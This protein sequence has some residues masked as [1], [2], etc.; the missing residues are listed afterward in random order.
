MLVGNTSNIASHM[1]RVQHQA[2]CS[3]SVGFIRNNPDTFVSQAT[4]ARFGLI[5]DREFPVVN[6]DDFR[7]GGARRKAFENA[8]IEGWSSRGTIYIDMGSRRDEIQALF[9]EHTAK[10][11]TVVNLPASKK[12][13]YRVPHTSWK[14]FDERLGRSAKMVLSTQRRD[15]EL[16]TDPRHQTPEIEAFMA[17]AQ[18]TAD[19]MFEVNVAI[20]Q[21]LDN[22]LKT[23]NLFQSMIVSPQGEHIS[24]SYTIN[25][26][27]E[28]V[29]PNAK[30]DGP[31]GQ[32]VGLDPHVDPTL[33]TL[34]PG[35]MQRGLFMVRCSSK[36]PDETFLYPIAPARGQI[37]VQGGLLIHFMT[38]E[39]IRANIHGVYR[40]NPDRRESIAM[41]VLPG[42]EYNIFDAA[43]SKY[44]PNIYGEDV[45][46]PGRHFGSFNLLNKPFH[47]LRIPDGYLNALGP[48]FQ[49]GTIVSFFFSQA[50]K[51]S[52][53]V[54]A[55][56]GRG[57]VAYRG[58]HDLSGAPREYGEIIYPAL[59]R[60]TLEAVYRYFLKSY[61]NL[62][63]TKHSRQELQKRDS[64]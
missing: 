56:Q 24:E 61:V 20:A 8:L 50:S 41:Q 9:D 45:R 7:A 18:K 37:A 5:R 14:G 40:D 32:V 49:P 22:V 48:R 19:A 39:K 23:G 44:L 25:H 17:Q 27:Y 30:R 29:K 52:S 3:K 26:S 59:Q 6:M 51:A 55:S 43:N 10:L 12:D 46:I 13:P 42:G 63:L 62:S 54:G 21:S 1:N 36:H 16:P 31:D 47:G 2:V 33:W 28:P 15:W 34:V 58:L 35:G 64:G 57:N 11:R 60:Q 53:Q 38:N 4:P